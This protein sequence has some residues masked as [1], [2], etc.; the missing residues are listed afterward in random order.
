M[1]KKDY[2][3]VANRAL[4]LINNAGSD[5]EVIRNEG[6]LIDK[7]QPWLGE[8]VVPIPYSG[9]G[10]LLSVSDGDFKQ[11]PNLSTVK[12]DKKI[13]SDPVRLQIEPLIGDVVTHA[14]IDWKVTMVGKLKPAE[15]VVLWTLFVSR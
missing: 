2:N 10:V 8:D 5:I 9:N 11:Y 15:T 7:E 14:G 12:A 13:Y 6:V 3:K 4:K 1:P